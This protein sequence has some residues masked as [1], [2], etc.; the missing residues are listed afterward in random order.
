MRRLQKGMSMIG[1][2]AALVIVL[3]AT[4]FYISGGLG[5]ME[6]PEERPD[7][8]GETL[9]GRSMYA[10]KDSNC[11]TQL[12]QLRMSV[13]VNTDHVSNLLPARIEDLNMGAS[14]YLCPVGEEK[15]DYDPTT[16]VV[17]CPHKGH[18]DY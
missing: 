8:K 15:Y 1:M 18:E 9:I 14:Y 6:A 11:R 12:Q 2:L 16:G 7:G 3:L 10:A 13:E 17:K 5:L 4:V